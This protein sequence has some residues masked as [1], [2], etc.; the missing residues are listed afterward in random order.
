M[1]K[2]V[3]V[4]GAAV[5]TGLATAKKLHIICRKKREELYFFSL[6]VYNNINYVLK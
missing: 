5:G 6:F 4:T 2:A 3:F 1:K